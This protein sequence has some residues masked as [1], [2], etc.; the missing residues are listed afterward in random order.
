MPDQ[1]SATDKSLK[2]ERERLNSLIN[3]MGDGVIA[4]DEHFKIAITNGAALN[5]LDVNTPLVGKPISS[6]LK[7]IDKDNEPLNLHKIIR[8]AKTAV[9]SRDW[10]LKLHDHDSE[11]INLDVSIAPVHLGYGRE[12]TR[13]YILIIRDITREK[14]LEEERD[15]F[16]SVASHE[17]RTPVAIAEGNISNAQFIFKQAGL[18]H[19]DVEE[20]LAQAHNQVVFLS[21]M[22]DDLAMLARAERG[23]LV[24]EIESINV[25]K[26]IEELVKTYTPQAA[27]KGLKL[28]TELDPS[29]E[30]L[31]SSRLYT[32]E[33]LQNFITN[34]I[35]YT[36]KGHITFG[37]RQT[38]SGVEFYVSDTG[39]GISRSD[40]KKLFEK[41]FRSEDY[42][43]RQ[44]SGTGLG[45]YI[46]EKLAR[47]LYAKID[48]ESQ[49]GHGSTFTIFIPDLQT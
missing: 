47:L 48:V 5:I 38:S 20:A 10:R 40:Q 3:N 11:K 49:I 14:T 8:E 26:L 21:E 32:K 9:T 46:T 43:T 1:P 45:L 15:E 44:T 22:V 29:L 2:L 39:I 23:K 31:Q 33:I 34:S 16:I 37:A 36:E 24:T 42:H 27:N 13:G 19:N 25:H 7:L 17:L 6:V 18:K 4:I 30:L 28:K 12:G 35:K 41:F